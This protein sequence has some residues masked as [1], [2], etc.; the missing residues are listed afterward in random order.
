[1]KAH[2]EAEALLEKDVL[3]EDERDFALENWHPGAENN[4]A[5]AGVFITPMDLAADFALEP[6]CG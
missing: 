6:G 4:V 2:A 1:M 3:S 5:V